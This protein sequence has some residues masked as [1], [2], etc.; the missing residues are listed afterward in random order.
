MR[1]VKSAI[2]LFSLLPLLQACG[3]SGNDSKTTETRMDDL[4]SV[5]GTISDDMVNTDQ[6]TDEAPIDASAP[7]T[8]K[9]KAKSEDSDKPKDEAKSELKVEDKAP[10]AT[11]KIEPTDKTAN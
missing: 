4:D 9:P 10:K 7:D 11:A 6:S 8:A 3:G 2:M 1:P 5:E